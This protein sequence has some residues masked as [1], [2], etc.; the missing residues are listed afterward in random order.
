MHEVLAAI[1]ATGI[2]TGLRQS[3]WTYPLVNAGHI[4][5]IALIVGAIAPFD[6]RLMGAWRGIPL[7]TFMQVLRPV[8]AAGVVLTV[9]T[10]ALLFVVQA[11]EYG[12]T[13]IFQVKMALVAL[14]LTNVA[15]HSGATLH[16]ASPAR[17][18]IAGALS[19]G[20]WVTI[21]VCGRMIAYV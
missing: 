7:D 1:E 16:A 10:G 13:R 20:L 11:T 18:R 21:L 12:P 14:A 9:A 17:C 15:L 8:A 19:L 6:L 5:G 3:R 4:L 2:A